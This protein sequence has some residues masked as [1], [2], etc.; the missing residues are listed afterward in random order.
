V[1]GGDEEGKAEKVED[2][3]GLAS[4][5]NRQH[6]HFLSLSRPHLPLRFYETND[7]LLIYGLDSV[8]NLN[9]KR[10]VS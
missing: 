5:P 8:Q 7:F 6:S 3:F 10:R 4:L 2:S 9:A 1:L